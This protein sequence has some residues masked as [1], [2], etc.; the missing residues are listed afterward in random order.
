MSV[1]A[2]RQWYFAPS[3]AENIC[4]AAVKEPKSHLIAMAATICFERNRQTV[5]LGYAVSLAIVRRDV[6]MV[7]ADGEDATVLVNDYLLSS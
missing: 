3:A 5:E 6:K 7:F 4:C 2:L 1:A